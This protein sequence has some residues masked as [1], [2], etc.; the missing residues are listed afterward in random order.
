LKFA[1][2][3]MLCLALISGAAVCA[4]GRGNQLPPSN[5]DP[6]PKQAPEPAPEPAAD[7]TPAEEQKRS[8]F[9]YVDPSEPRFYAKLG[10]L[11]GSIL[12]ARKAYRQMKMR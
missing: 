3:L 1:F 12:L 8:I 2:K 10:L 5:L 7:E 11:L 6:P 4:Q 9:D